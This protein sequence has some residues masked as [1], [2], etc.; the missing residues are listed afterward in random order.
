MTEEARHIAS[1]SMRP[2]SLSQQNSRLMQFNPE[3]RC[4]TVALIQLLRL[5]ETTA[6]L[7]RHSHRPRG[8]APTQPALRHRGWV[9]VRRIRSHRRSSYRGHGDCSAQTACRGRFNPVAS[10]CGPRIA[11]LRPTVRTVDPMPHR[12]RPGFIPSRGV[13]ANAY[14]VQLQDTHCTETLRWSGRWRSQQG[15]RRFQVWACAD[16][17]QGL[18]GLREFG[19]GRPWSWRSYRRGARRG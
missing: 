16:H 1:T 10:R 12:D 2:R 4:V 11:G 19:R 3:S 14:G 7:I 6:L 15:D 18:T 13:L 5:Y 8:S 9:A 17:L